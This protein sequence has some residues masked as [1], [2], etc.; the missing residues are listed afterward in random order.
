MNASTLNTGGANAV[1]WFEIVADNGSD[2]VI[3]RNIIGAAKRKIKSQ[4]VPLEKLRLFPLLRSRDA[5]AWS[6]RP[7]AW[8]LFVQDPETRR[9]RTESEMAQTPM[10]WEIQLVR[11]LEREGYDVTYCTDLD[12][13]ENANLLLTH[14][15]FLTVGHDEYWSWQMRKNVETARDRGINLGFFSANA[16]FWQVRFEPSLANG[17]ANRTMVC[18]KDVTL[19]PYWTDSDPTNNQLTTVL[20]RSQEIG[21]AEDAM[22]GVTYA[23]DAVDADMVIVNAAHWV[24]ANTGLK[25]GDHI[26]R[27]VGYECDSIAWS[28][29]PGLQDIAHSPFTSRIRQRA[30]QPSLPPARFN[31]TGA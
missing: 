17:A 9:G 23:R 5:E 13:H 21:L 2:G 1:Y 7:S 11:F 26:P 29:P 28:T 30:A 31:G 24:C 6:A 19:D 14:K 25:N 8:L 20:W 4:P 15:G 12:N 3:A 18:Y 22:I 10:W 16:C 27:I